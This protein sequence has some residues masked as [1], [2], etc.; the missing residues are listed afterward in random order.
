M[1]RYLKKTKSK[2]KNPFRKLVF[3]ITKNIPRGHVLTYGEVARRA[4]SPRASRAVGSILAQNFDPT[5][6]CHRVIRADGWVGEY[7]RGGPK[8]KAEIL[9]K[10]GWIITHDKIL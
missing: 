5:I 10:E 3:S 6:P 1:P 9:K 4:G 2:D 8:R 7:N